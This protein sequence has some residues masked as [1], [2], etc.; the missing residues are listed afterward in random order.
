[1]GAT[2]N[3]PFPHQ[4]FDSWASTYNDDVSTG[5]GFFVEGYNQ[6]LNQVYT[7]SKVEP[8]MRILDLGTGT[9]NL[10]EIFTKA[11][12]SL[13]CSDFSHKMILVA[14]KLLPGSRF[15]LHDLREPIPLVTNQIFDR[16]VSSYVF[17]HFDQEKKIEIVTRTINSHLRP[18]GMMVIGD[19]SFQ[20]HEDL[21]RQKMVL[22]DDWID[23][24]YWIASQVIPLFDRA[25]LD[26]VYEQLT[27]NAGVYILQKQYPKSQD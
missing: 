15:F 4:E 6:I 19:I 26:T 16:I 13:W 2:M 22:K 21:E 14:H 18:G 12:C 20:T 1:M 27:P 24:H 17:H 23:E 9:G 7:E 8:G 11:G 25:G 5:Q 3:D 10:A